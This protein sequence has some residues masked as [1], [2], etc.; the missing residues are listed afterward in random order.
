MKQPLISIILPTYKHPPF[1]GRAI[2]SVQAQSYKNWELLIIDDGLD[3]EAVAVIEEFKE[4]DIRIHSYKNE[5]NTGIQKSLNRGINEAMGEYIARIDDDDIWIDTQKLKKQVVFLEEH[6][7]YVLVGTNGSIVN[8]RGD[9]YGTYQLSQSDVQI[10][11]SILSKNCFLHPSVMMRKSTINDAGG[12]DESSSMKHIEDYALWLK[13]GM[14]GKFANLQDNTVILMVHEDSLT[15]NNRIS[16][17]YK[18]RI[19]IGKYKYVYSGYIVAYILLTMRIIGFTFLKIIP[20]PNR[21]LY[22]IQK[23]YKEY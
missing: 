2:N 11:R 20:I 9:V 18:M 14:L 23:I 5:K 7:E 21:L 6:K 4:N 8:E 16:Q 19:L 10:R 22:V 3:P 1:L 17:A 12:Y 13:L 15:F